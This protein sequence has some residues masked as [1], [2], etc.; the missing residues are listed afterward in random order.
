MTLRLQTQ[1]E[2]DDDYFL[3]LYRA[4]EVSLPR[5]LDIRNIDRN[6]AADLCQEAML[7]LL[8]SRAVGIRVR[9]PL[10]YLIRIAHNIWVDDLRAMT[11]DP[12]ASHKQLPQDGGPMSNDGCQVSARSPEEVAAAREIRVMW[13]LL[14]QQLPS[15][16]REI[17][18]LQ[19]MQEMPRVEIS[20]WLQSWRPVSEEA[21]RKLIRQAHQ[22]LRGLSG[23]PAEHPRVRWP[24]RYCLTKNP[25][26]RS[27]A[28][29]SCRAIPKFV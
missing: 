17:A 9:H 7:R 8:R 2:R 24:Q 25:W 27:A 6:F 10:A 15:P 14:S 22:M 4:L 23:S 20:H 13:P 26:M 16:Y 18:T 28:P 3:V 5:A 19:F 29:S 11:A 1:Q 21:C 12:L